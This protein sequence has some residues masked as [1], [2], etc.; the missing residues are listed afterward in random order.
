MKLVIFETS[1]KNHSVMIYNWVSICHKNGWD[2]LIITTEDIFDQ[3]KADISVS[4]ANVYFLRK[5]SVVEFFKA[6]LKTYGA[7]YLVVTSLQNYFLHYLILLFCPCKILLTVHNVNTWF[8]KHWVK[9]I[10]GTL[11]KFVRYAWRV[12]TTRYI[13]NSES[14]KDSL[15]HLGVCEQLLT[16][17]PFAMRH[18]ELGKLNID[19]P[20]KALSVVYP[21]MVSVYRKDYNFFLKLAQEYPLVNFILL[22]KLN[23]NEGAAEVV[24]Y[25]TS[26]NIENVQVFESFVDQI[27]FD[28]IM[29]ESDILFSYININY[30]MQGIGELYGKTKDSGI[31]YLMAEYA[32]PLIVN[33]DFEN[34][35]HLKPFTRYYSSY[36]S[37]LEIFNTLIADSKLKVKIRKEIVSARDLSSIINVSNSIRSFLVNIK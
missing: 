12:R 20:S 3:V 4:S 18:C 28:K 23:F 8:G 9:T 36:N 16:V 29:K 1:C 37:L 32:L 35:Q 10:N 30:C 15:I 27:T 34:F 6:L 17:V 24:N 22:G 31:S 2:F 26:N 11:K 25:I 33:S 19:K 13:V 5:Y 14:M 21:G 7:D